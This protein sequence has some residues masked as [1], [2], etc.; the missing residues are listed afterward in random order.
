MPNRNRH[1]ASGCIR[2]SGGD[3]ASRLCRIVDELREVLERHAPSELA[4][5]RVFVSRNAA[6][7]LKLG[8]A[9]GA[10]LVAF[11]GIPVFEYAATRVKQA[12]TGNGNATKRQ[13]QHMVRLLLALPE[14]PQAD[15]ADALAVA[16]CHAHSRDMLARMQTDHRP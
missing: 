14:A 16:L 10:A 6:S 13:V 9:R 2:L 8:Q 4:I 5:E 15:A 12:T 11:P 1:V 3:V 7:A